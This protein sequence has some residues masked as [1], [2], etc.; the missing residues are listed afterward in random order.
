MGVPHGGNG[1]LIFDTETTQVLVRRDI[2]WQEDM[3]E[4]HESAEVCDSHSESESYSD[5]SSDSSQDLSDASS[6]S[7]LSNSDT[8]DSSDGDGENE[9]SSDNEDDD[10]DPPRGEVVLSIK[11]DKIK[12]VAERHNVDPE[13]LC[14]LNMFNGKKASPSSKLMTNTELFLPTCTE[15]EARDYAKLYANAQFGAVS[16]EGIPPVFEK[17]LQQSGS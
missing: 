8:D 12:T 14:I 16:E 15:E 3:T 2:H 4:I 5:S 7:A 17:R 10:S 13:L 11:G 1:Y 9:T 6:E